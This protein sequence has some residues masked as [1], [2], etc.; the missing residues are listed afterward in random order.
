M[1]ITKNAIPR[2]TILRG[3]GAAVALPLL[4]SMV[5]AMTALAQTVANPVRRLGVVYLPNGMNMPSWTPAAEGGAFELTPTLEPL[6]PFRNRLVVVSGFANKEAD[7]R[8]GEGAGDHSRAQAAFLTGVHPKKTEGPDIHLGISMDQIAARELGRQTQLASLELALEAN[9]TMGSCDL[10][11]SCAYQSTIAWRSATTPLPME[12]DPRA[13]FERLFGAHS[14]DPRVRLAR[15]RDDRSIL[16]SVADEVGRLRSGLGPRDR[17]KL[18]EYLEAVRDIERRIQK[19]EEQSHRDLPVVD[20][21]A[22]IPAAFAD[23]TTLMF[24]LMALAYQADLTRV[25]TYLVGRELS[26]RTFPEIGVPDMHHG[27]SHHRD[28]PQQRA[29]LAKINSFHMKLFA[30]FLEK[31]RATPDGDGSLLDHSIILY[32][33]GISDGDTHAHDNLPILLVGGGAGRIKGGR[34]VR[35]SKD[36]PL[37]NLHAT[38]LDRIGI[39]IETLGDST[40]RVAELSAL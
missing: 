32:G 11:Y 18:T 9:D 30:T 31:L 27:V 39:P 15:I 28:D 19:T 1:I 13:V 37:M 3:I 33:G 34:H 35:V 12:T 16:D 24:D 40:G 4:D 14:T 26:N 20:Q 5:P 23:Y 6:S 36:T 7:G 21:P 10:G 8:P 2:R 29:K 38:L 17:A 22:G 25:A